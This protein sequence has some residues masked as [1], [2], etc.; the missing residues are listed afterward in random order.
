MMDETREQA[1]LRLKPY[2]ERARGFS[3]WDLSAAPATPLAAGPPWDYAARARELAR[4]AAMLLDIGTGGG[5][6]LSGVIA[7]LPLRAVASE[8]WH[9]NASV[10][11]A[12]L[13]PQGVGVV[14]CASERLPFATASF[15]L[16]LNRHEVLDPTEIARVLRPGG[17]ALTQQVGR[18]NWREL[19]RHF[20]R[21]TDFG[22]LFGAY[23]R[24]FA[25]AGLTIFTAA[26]HQRPVAYASLGDVVYLL[27]LMPWLVP[28]FALERDLDAL[29]AL[30]ADCTTTVGLVLS[31]NR[32]IIEAHKP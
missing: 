18:D 21:K 14:R 10:A 6:V 20:G 30:E 24:G 28:D 19:Q 17:V 4:S 1:L 31:E 7:G 16:V 26:E 27:A 11:S 12:R 2:I 9:I 32:F 8:E 3:G 5:E 23:R 22:D 25:R 29:L 13:A 15:D